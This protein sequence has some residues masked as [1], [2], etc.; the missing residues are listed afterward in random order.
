MLEQSL[1]RLGYG[2]ANLGNLHRE[3]SDETSWA[4]LDAA[5]DSGI[6]YF[7]TAPHYGL[8]LS[9]RRL[10]QFLQTKPRSEYI[11]STKVGRLLVPDLACAG[12][13]DTANDFLVPAD[14]RRVWDF[15][16]DGIARS[17][18]ESLQRMGLDR[19]DI[20]YLHDPERYDLQVGLGSGLA[21]ALALRKQGVVSA[22]GVGSMDTAALQ[23]AA[24]TGA[25]DVLM[26][27][28][29]YTLLEQTVSAGVLP[30]CE[31]HSTAVVLASVFNT[32]M[33]ARDELAA[34]A[35]YEYGPVPTAMRTRYQRV[36]DICHAHGVA[37]PV[38]AVQFGLRNPVVQSVIVGAATAQ[39][40]TS[41][42]QAMTTAVPEALWEELA[43]SGLLG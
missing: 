15:S 21:G 6:R 20:I 9:E 25:L 26:I 7:D 42:V 30:S 5:W 43:A 8:G 1:P 2:A 29:R 32:G 39:Q 19:V 17:V 37:V 22:V 40:I 41:N 36:A 31:K 12:I 14:S 4:V 27:A 13:L 33:L 28:G 3:L 10:G 38:A 18:V 23:A 11:L 34:D 16:I 35:R 24:D